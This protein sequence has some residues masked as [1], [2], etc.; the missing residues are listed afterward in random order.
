MGRSRVNG[1]RVGHSQSRRPGQ[2]PR[3]LI[4]KP[5]AQPVADLDSQRPGTLTRYFA[6]ICN[7]THRTSY[8]HMT[9]PIL[10][11]GRRT[12]SNNDGRKPIVTP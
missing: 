7:C 3:T 11:P 4:L 12:D 5:L 2:R 6:A 9:Y 8:T 1:D 10:R